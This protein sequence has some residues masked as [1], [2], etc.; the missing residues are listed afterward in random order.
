MLA[1]RFSPYRSSLSLP[2]PRYVLLLIFEPT[3]FENYRSVPAPRKR[4]EEEFTR[5]LNSR[6]R[7]IHHQLNRSISERGIPRR[8]NAKF[9][10]LWSRC[11]KSYAR[12]FARFSPL[13]VQTSLPPFPQLHLPP[14]SPLLRSRLLINFSLFRSAPFVLHDCMESFRRVS[15]IARSSIPHPPLRASFFLFFFFFFFFFFV[16]K[17]RVGENRKRK[18][19]KKERKRMDEGEEGGEEKEARSKERRV[20][21]FQERWFEYEYALIDS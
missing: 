19:R 10:R 2:R 12:P 13:P 7:R 18:E 17:Q 3:P 14:S 9:P 15:R 1:F 8:R 20:F 11:K 16:H 6:K 21:V 5:S 4:T